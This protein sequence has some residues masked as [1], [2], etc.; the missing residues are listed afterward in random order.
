MNN[1]VTLYHIKYITDMKFHSWST[2]NSQYTDVSTSSVLG[3]AA[4]FFSTNFL[5]SLLRFVHVYPFISL[6]LIHTNNASMLTIKIISYTTYIYYNKE[7]EDLKVWELI[8]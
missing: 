6:L 7:K 4:N 8:Y 2:N 5:V 1:L 3:V